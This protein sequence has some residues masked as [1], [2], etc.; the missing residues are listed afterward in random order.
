MAKRDFDI[1]IVQ[2]KNLMLVPP[3][4]CRMKIINNAAISIITI[5]LEYILLQIKVPVFYLK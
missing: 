3:E 1:L 5:N 2:N 4:F